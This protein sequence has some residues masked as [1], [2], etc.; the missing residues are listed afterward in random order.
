MKVFVTGASGFIGSHVTRALLSR[1]HSVAVLTKSADIP[2]RLQDIW[3]K[4]EKNPGKLDDLESLRLALKEIQPEACIHLAWYAEP[5]KYLESPENLNCLKTSL[6][7]FHELVQVECKQIVGAGTCAEYAN[8][9]EPL[10]EDSPTG[11][12]TPY[13]SAK[14]SCLMLGRQL[15]ELAKIHFAWGRIFYPYGPMEDERRVIP[16]LIKSLTKGEFFPATSGEQVRD[17]IHVEDVADAFCVLAE[18]QAH[19]VFNICSGQP[20]TLRQLLEIVGRLVGRGELIQFGIKSPYSW[21]P[22]I[23]TG[24]NQRLKAI[25]WKSAYSLEQGLGK[26]VDWFKAHPM[27]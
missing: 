6:E 15:A 3:G 9:S 22:P 20:R 2:W 10:K 26:T 7:L 5:G 14:L 16:A 23:L 4:L 25:G 27:H 12:A 1:G 18:K 13:A 21:E 19:N 24:E 11:P 17:Y 8:S